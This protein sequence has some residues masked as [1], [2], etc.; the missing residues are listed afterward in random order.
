MGL[1]TRK[2]ATHR[3]R[4]QKNKDKMQTLPDQQS[5]TKQPIFDWSVLEPTPLAVT[6]SSKRAQQ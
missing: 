1:L 5:S 4:Q 6:T 2:S 3:S